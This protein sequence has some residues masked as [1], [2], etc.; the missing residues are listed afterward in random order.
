MLAREFLRLCALEALAP[1]G[2]PESGP[3]PTLAG[4]YVFDTRL[5][6]IDDLAGPLP[7]I[8]VYTENEELTKISQA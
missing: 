2:A 8:S 4:K 5:D 6:P 7:V 3:W 1:S